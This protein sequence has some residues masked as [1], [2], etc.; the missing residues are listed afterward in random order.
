[1]AYVKKEPL[2]AWLEHMGVSAYIVNT[3]Q[4]ETH[5]PVADVV[6]MKHGE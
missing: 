1:M 3:I 2:C 5:F 4:D 6:K